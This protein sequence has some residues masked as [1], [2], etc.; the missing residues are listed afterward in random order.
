MDCNI[1]Y[2]EKDGGWQYIISYKVDG[3]WKQKSKQ[4]FPLKKD[5]KKAAEDRLDELKKEMELT[6]KVEPQYKGITFGKFAE[7]LIEHEKLHKTANTIRMRK[8]AVEKFKDIKNIPLAELSSIQVQKCVDKMVED[9]LK[10]STI[11]ANLLIFKYILNQ[12]VR[13]YKIISASPAQD[14]KIPAM[15][16][17]EKGKEEKAL[18]KHETEK[19]L[20]VL[21]SQKASLKYYYLCSFA[22]GTGLRRGELLGLTWDNVDFKKNEVCI[23][24]QWKLLA[25]GTEGFGTLKKRNSKRV[26]PVA[27]STM[28]ELREYRKVFN[29]V[30]MDNRIFPFGSTL[31]ARK[32]I[33]VSSNLDFA[34]SMHTL[35]HTYATNLIA[36]GVDFKTAAAILGHDVEMTMRVYS[37]VTD[38]M[39]KNA[40]EKINKIF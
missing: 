22:L 14:I 1:T 39:M 28:D 3:K 29:V 9:E 16:Y 31:V 33:N 6:A 20:G 25:D 10:I 24:R 5:A 19:F 40:A 17:S 35:R 8:I 21:K 12:A 11:K 36:N 27:K 2:R 15:Q 34:V 32:M 38:E 18:E 7:E 23:V 37:H 4:G 30:N 26:V 13:P